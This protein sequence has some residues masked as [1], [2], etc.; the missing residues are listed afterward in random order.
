[1]NAQEL[2]DVYTQLCHGL[3]AAGEAET[4][5]VLARLVLLLLLQVPSAAAAS[6]AV[7]DALQGTERTT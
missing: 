4:P 7:A 6:Q 2:D 5:N 3:T 1:M